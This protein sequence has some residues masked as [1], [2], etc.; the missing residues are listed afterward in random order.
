MFFV[1]RMRL[2][3]RGISMQCRI[4][5]VHVLNFK[6]FSENGIDYAIFIL[7]QFKFAGIRQRPT[8]KLK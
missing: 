1:I 8:V 3:F 5:C 4:F 2:M 7:C 6:C